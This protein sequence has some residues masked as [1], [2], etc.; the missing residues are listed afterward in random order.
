[1]QTCPAD[2]IPTSASRRKIHNKKELD[3]SNSFFAFNRL[4]GKLLA[5]FTADKANQHC[6]KQNDVR[7]NAKPNDIDKH[8]DKIADMQFLAFNLQRFA[9]FV[10]N[11]D[12]A[13]IVR[14]DIKH[15][16]GIGVPA[17]VMNN[18]HRKRQHHTGCKHGQRLQN[19]FMDY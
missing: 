10:Q 13:L 4:F 5:D 18:I 11:G 12:I 6:K 1:M 8:K 3:F 15:I 7:R 2:Y 17:C 16:E 19:G 14:P 9:D